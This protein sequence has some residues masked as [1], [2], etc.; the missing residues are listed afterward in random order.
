MVYLQTKWLDVQA[1]IL[2]TFVP[3]TL[4]QSSNLFD[5]PPRD[6]DLSDVSTAGIEAWFEQDLLCVHE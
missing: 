4:F 1:S 2:V 6:Q 3:T 5:H